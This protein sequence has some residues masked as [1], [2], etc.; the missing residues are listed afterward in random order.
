MQYIRTRLLLPLLLLLPACSQQAGG[1]API[2]EAADAAQPAFRMLVASDSQYP[3]TNKIAAA[4][5]AARPDL[6]SE[7]DGA[8]K[9]DIKEISRT[10]NERHVKSMNL[11]GGS[12]SRVSGVIMNGDLTAYGHGSERDVF[13]EI[14]GDLELRLYPGLGNH[15]Y[16][17]NVDNTYENRAATGSI[18]LLRDQVEALGI[19]DFD[20]VGSDSYEFPE[21]E[22]RIQGSL[23][24]SWTVDDVHFV[25]LNNYPTYTTSYS[26][27]RSDRG[28]RYTVEIN[29]ALAWLESDLIE[30]RNAGQAIILNMHDPSQ[31]WGAD[32]GR[33]AFLELIQTY[34]VSAV[35]AGHVH[36][37]VG[38]EGNLGG[39]PL[40]YS[41]SSSYSQYVL[42]DFFA[43]EM[44]V[45]PVDSS[46][47]DHADYLSSGRWR[48]GTADRVPLDK[49]VPPTPHEAVSP[50]GRVT[51]FNEGGYVARF[52][53]TYMLDGEQVQH[54]T[55]NI[56]LGN[57]RSF[58][59][60]SMATDI[61]AFGEAN[62]GLIWDPWGEIFDQSYAT[63]PSICLK[64]YGT[65]LDRKW[66]TNCE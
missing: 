6:I 9:G 51:F 47:V 23:A 56:L 60:P 11:L 16:A 39:V 55:G 52:T 58:A 53:L 48:F 8:S 1:Q 35:F 40:F 15:D 43:D 63:P 18:E 10:L 14:Y 4:E 3:W 24:Y 27:F 32:A 49:T 50:G 44:V 29:D 19:Q 65:T 7:P 57:K 17:N 2:V 61:R 34:G 59:I 54:E 21:L 37:S 5:V 20:F 30:A 45:Q 13:E 22:T 62:T 64:A 31:Q 38:R 36:S 42:V 41:G 46:S 66:D 12:L 25:Q 28:R 26:N 33:E